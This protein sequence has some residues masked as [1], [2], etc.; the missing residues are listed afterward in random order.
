MGLVSAWLRSL[1][2]GKTRLCRLEK[3]QSSDSDSDGVALAND[4]DLSD[5]ELFGDAAWRAANRSHRASTKSK[6]EATSGAGTEL[7]SASGKKRGRPALQAS[8]DMAASSAPET[9]AAGV[10]NDGGTVAA[11]AAKRVVLGP[12]NAGTEDICALCEDGGLL[13]VCDGTLDKRNAL[14]TCALR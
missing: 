12:M 13:L 10:V 4:D 5:S 8:Q 6:P 2:G 7:A 1:E 3:A 11:A 14:F 9:S